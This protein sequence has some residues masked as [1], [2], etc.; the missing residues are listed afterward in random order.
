MTER[1]SPTEHKAGEYWCFISYRHAD[2]HQQ[3]RDWASWL[4]REIERYEVPAELVGTR[5]SR[6][7]LLPE[8]IYPVFRDEE[9][10]P[11]N[12]DL[13]SSIISALDR[14]RFLVALCSPRSV[15]SQYVAQEIQHFKQS[16][17]AERIVAVILDGEPGDGARECFPPPLRHPVDAQGVIDASVIEEPIAADFRLKEGDQVCEGFT[18]PEAYRRSLAQRGTLDRRDIERRAEAYGNQLQ[19]MKLKIIAGILGVQL[20]QLRDRDKAYQLELAQKRSR[21][22]KRWLAALAILALLA[23]A[24]GVISWLQSQEAQRQRNNALRESGLSLREQGRQAFVAGAPLEALTYLQQSLERLPDDRISRF[25]VNRSLPSVPLA[26]LQHSAPGAGDPRLQAVFSPDRSRVVTASSADQHVRLFDAAS[27]RPLLVLPAPDSADAAFDGVRQ[28]PSL[29]FSPDG[30]SLLVSR[31]DPLIALYDAASGA[32]QTTLRGH[33]GAVRALTFSADGRRMISASADGTARVWDTGDWRQLALLGGF[34]YV[35]GASLSPDAATA[36]VQGWDE[37]QGGLRAKLFD[38]ASGRVLASLLADA[39]DAHSAIFSPDG[40]SIAVQLQ[41]AI[42]VLPLTPDGQGVQ[43]AGLRLAVSRV[44]SLAFSPDSSRLL[45]AS[46]DGIGRLWDLPGGELLAE[47]DAGS[48]ALSSAQFSPDGQHIVTTYPQAREAWVWDVFSGSQLA[49]LGGHEHQVLSASFSAD[50]QRLLTTTGIAARIYDASAIGPQLRLD[51]HEGDVESLQYSADGSRLLT[52]DSSGTT[53]LFE[54]PSGTQLM[55][56]E[57]QADWS[58]RSASLAQ[59]G[60]RLLLVGS[61]EVARLFAS[62]SPDSLSLSRGEDWGVI[63]AHFSPDGTRIVSACSDGYARLFDAA[64]GALQ[65]TLQQ[66]TDRNQPPAFSP[67]GRTLL[68][69]NRIFD[70]ATGALLA[71]TAA[72]AAGEPG[73]RLASV[74]AGASSQIDDASYSADGSRILLRGMHELWVYNAGLDRLL[75]TL[76]GHTRNPNDLFMGRRSVNSAAFSPDGQRVV[77]AGQDQLVRIWDAVTGEQLTSAGW[78][79]KAVESASFSPDG[80]L[81][82]TRSHTDASARLFDA[83]TGKSLQILSRFQSGIYSHAIF[84]P[85]GLHA[86]TASGHRVRIWDISG[87]R[88]SAQELASLV[89]Q[90]VPWRMTDEG[91]VVPESLVESD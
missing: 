86:A 67:D 58:V 76:R 9:S 19:L 48:G 54:L 11:A 89:L 82:L 32:L 29:A 35:N 91:V 6:G 31:G 75:A 49:Q 37:A 69:G 23:L 44:V 10:L 81:L 2:N 39:G 7:D 90:R 4:H 13:A 24:G 73:D 53:R 34:S 41:D 12:A 59:Q 17:K 56:I 47:L 79:E 83:Q 77:S 14:S 45:A 46:L 21:T 27:G 87:Y 64:S 57:P 16:G 68:S 71:T 22:L 50:G 30:R 8:R 62:V 18:S 74:I 43:D 63:A 80:S 5:N 60:D 78:H 55:R 72:P 1:Q 20:E 88:Q 28:P 84:S 70:A 85:D 25:L 26:L 38:V 61:D 33:A 66:P 36:L 52:L 40:R 42:V 3:D 15:E 65:L 51:G